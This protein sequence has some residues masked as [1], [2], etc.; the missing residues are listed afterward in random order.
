MANNNNRPSY[1]EE[2]R[3]RYS[4]PNF[5]N[6]P[7]SI[8]DIAKNVTRIIR[9]AYFDMISDQDYIYFKTPNVINTCIQE[10]YERYVK[11]LTRAHAASCYIWQITNNYSNMSTAVN[12]NGININEERAVAANDQIAANSKGNV[13]YNVFLI[14][15]DIRNGADPKTALSFIKFINKRDILDL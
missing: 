6:K 11:Y 7:N 14:M 9:D 2:K 13:W 4:D 15:T 12:L 10:S 1:F 5:F 3:S 8:E